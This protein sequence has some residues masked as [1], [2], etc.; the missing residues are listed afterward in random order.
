MNPNARVFG[1]FL[2]KLEMWPSK[3]ENKS[4]E[5]SANQSP[6]AKPAQ[7][8]PESRCTL[9]LVCVLSTTQLMLSLTAKSWGWK[10]AELLVAPGGWEDEWAAVHSDTRPWRGRFKP[11]TVSLGRSY[12]SVVSLEAFRSQHRGL[13]F[14][15]HHFWFY[16]QNRL[17]NHGSPKVTRFSLEVR[18]HFY[19]PLPSRVRLK[20]S[21]FLTGHLRSLHLL[22]HSTNVSWACAVRQVRS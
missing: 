14:P 7:C 2:S 8:K 21:F 11:C 15:W 3:S 5:P 6:G 13:F 22:I 12:P 16:G 17:C 20:S 19:L 18:S 9:H 4:E 10:R 1:E